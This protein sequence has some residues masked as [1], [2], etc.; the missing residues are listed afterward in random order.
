MDIINNEN[1]IDDSLINTY[2]DTYFITKYRLI[3]DKSIR[4]ITISLL[5]FSF[6][7]LSTVGLGDYVPK[8]NSERLV[9][10]VI[11]L[12]GISIFSLIM[13]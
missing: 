7:T 9:I 2:E 12:F 8:S 3:G 13:G 5:Y 11:F 1:F 6:T 4:R 10:I